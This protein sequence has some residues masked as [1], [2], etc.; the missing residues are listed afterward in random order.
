MLHQDSL[1]TVGFGILEPADQLVVLVRHHTGT[2]RVKVAT[3]TMDHELGNQCIQ[4]RVHSRV[5]NLTG[6]QRV[7]ELHRDVF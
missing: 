4:L 3:G 2:G 1:L 5:R 6:D 7:E